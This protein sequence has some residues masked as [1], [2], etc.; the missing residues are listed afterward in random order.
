[1]EL[2]TK[3]KTEISDIDLSIPGP[4]AVKQTPIKASVKPR[5]LIIDDDSDNLT[6]LRT[7][8]KGEY[9]VCEASCGEDGIS[10]AEERN[11]DCIL[12][13]IMMNGMDGYSAAKK[14]RGMD[15]VSDI[16][17]IAVTARPV[18]CERELIMNS[19]FD[20]FLAKPLNIDRLLKTVSYWVHKCHEH[21]TCD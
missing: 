5:V 18:E 11:P 19:G 14:I 20:D 7:I 2:P 15:G 12:L 10:L 1:V 9:D 21:N 4:G 13:D 17:I 8:L 3:W 16:P 6:A